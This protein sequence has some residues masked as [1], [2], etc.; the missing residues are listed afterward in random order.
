M[1]N[2][3]LPEKEQR[4]PRILVAALDW[5]LGHASRCIP[6]IDELRRQGA[7]VFL[8]ASGAAAGLWKLTYPDLPLFALPAYGIR[9]RW[10]NMYLNMLANAPQMAWAVVAEHIRLRRLVRQYNIDIVISD[11]R[12]G[13]FHPGIRSIYMTHQLHIQAPEPVGRWLINAFHR[14]VIRQYDECWVPDAAGEDNLAGALSHPP[15]H[16]ATT[17]IG[18][19]SRLVRPAIPLAFDIVAVL[20]GPEPQRSR[21]EA[22]ILRQLADIAV[23][24]LLIRG[25]PHARALR[26]VPGH[27]EVWNFASGEQIAAALAGARLIVCRSGYSTLMDLAAMGRPALLIPTPGQTEQVY[28]AGYYK[29]KNFGVVQQQGRLQL[30]RALREIE[31]CSSPELALCATPFYSYVCSNVQR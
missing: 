13:C 18:H 23:P 31:N 17:Y 14:V 10:A 15:V 6:I 11:N 7:E 25:A 27:I 30:D 12:L 21:L 9:Y 3:Q 24:S 22:E 28:L 16:P 8:A 2:T 5:G 26:E 1:K 19:L 4:F 29:N 20:S